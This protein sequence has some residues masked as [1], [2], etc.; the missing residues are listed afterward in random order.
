MRRRDLLK[1]IGASVLQFIFR[2]AS[3][4]SFARKRT[5][6]RV[7]PSDPLWPSAD[8]WEKLKAAVDGN[9]IRPR[10]M[11]ADCQTDANGQACAEV[12][13]NIRNPF[14]IGDQPAGT[15]VS[16][17]LD[18]WTPAPSAYVVKASNSANVATAV[19]FARENNLRL[20]VKGGGHSYL[21]TSNAPDSLMIW[22]RAMNKVTLHDAFVPQGCKAQSAP[23]PAV[24]AEAGAMWIDLYHAVTTE[25]GRYVQGGGCTTV[26]VAGLV[27]SG[28]FG[29]FSKGFGTAA[30][31]LLEAEV[32]TADGR[33]R[34]ANACTNPDLFWAIK[35]GGG[36]SFGVVTKVTLRTHELPEFFGYVGGRIKAQSDDAFRH[37]IELFINFYRE[38]LFNSHWGEQASFGP[39]NTLRLSLGCQGLDN[40]QV[41]NLWKPFFDSVKDSKDFVASDLEA[42]AGRSR[43]YWD[44]VARKQRGNDSM[45][46][47]SRPGAPAIHGY[48][49][50]D[51]GQ[52]GAF[53]HGYDSLWLPASL[54]EK[55]QQPRLVD[56]LFAASRHKKFEMHFNKGIAGATRTAI[57]A[58]KD[59]ATNPAVV[60]SFVL[61]I[62][63]DGGFPAYPGLARPGS[64]SL[65]ST[66]ILAAA[67]NNKHKID[68]AAAELRK[69]APNAGSYVSESNYFNASWQKAYWGTN[70]PTL[71]AIKKKY[72]PEGLFFVHHGVGSE[73]WSADGFTRVVKGS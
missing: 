21:G 39:D 66:G 27:Q 19:N 60:D 16:G 50:G 9:L 2:P 18:A 56:A 5:L 30:A 28:G 48:W 55:D 69:I 14:Y 43:H 11:V 40:Q 53:L 49:S 17:W 41:V 51:Q 13:K 54:L 8:N 29:S 22:T 42:G 71:R 68:L 58:T 62:I 65:N 52:V 6:N 20:V 46:G 7:R 57:A 38:N 32:V 36:G 47:D 10:A 73:E 31:G 1:A 61:V 33:I 3:A 37:L 4:L 64:D 24:T 35:G 25:A 26:G 12:R 70:Y 67:R 63:A 15:E 23:V 59:T 72:D 44:V 45:I 34:I